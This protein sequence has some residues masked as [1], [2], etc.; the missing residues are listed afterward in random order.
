MYNTLAFPVSFCNFYVN[1]SKS[2]SQ[3]MSLALGDHLPSTFGPH[4]LLNHGAYL[5]AYQLDRLRRQ[6]L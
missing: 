1:K 3:V 5:R 2:Q 6:T 4:L